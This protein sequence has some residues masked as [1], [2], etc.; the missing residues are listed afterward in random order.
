M[1]KV[2]KSQILKSLSDEWL[3][4]LQP[5]DDILNN[6][7]K[8]LNKSADDTTDYSPD[9]SLWF[10][11]ARLTDFTNI[12]VCI[13]GQDPYPNKQHAHGLAFSSKQKKV[14]ASLKNI[15]KCLVK[16]K[17]IKTKPDTSDLTNWAIQGVLLINT[18]FST[19]SGIAKCHVK[20]WKPYTDGLIK[21][22][23]E[24]INPVFLLWGGP[25]KKKQKLFPEY[26]EYF[27]YDHPSPLS[28]RIRKF[29]DFTGFNKTDDELKKRNIKIC[30]DPRIK[31]KPA[32]QIIDTR[33]SNLFD[34]RVIVF[35]DG[36]C[37][38]NASDSPKSLGGYAA[39]FSE[40]YFEDTLL[41]GSIA[42]RPH[43]AT[44]N[45]AEGAALYAVLKYLDKHEDKWDHVVIYSD[46][47]FWIEMFSTYMPAW[48]SKGVL[49]AERK[50]PDMT[51]PMWDLFKKLNFA[52]GKC[53]EF[54]HVRGHNKNGWMKYPDYTYEY[55]CAKNNDYVDKWATY[56][57]KKYKP[58]DC[59][60][61]KIQ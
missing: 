22:L 56:A 37:W 33:L 23:A 12:H 18:A 42:N 16:Q 54:T 1:N 53:I 50:N 58:G 35:T 5:L 55:Y 20:I 15:Y 34:G 27:M 10:E 57:R 26:I 31:V 14:P 13:V 29:E 49:F 6:V 2:E 30:W 59:F 52:V 24:K 36:S 21:L 51:V 48:E 25:A 47:K 39:Y 11:W 45:R 38:P 43:Y 41:T 46:S 40:G 19:L 44:N 28:Q 17:L 8:E 60:E 61:K 7:L 9:P 3:E 4:F 32:E